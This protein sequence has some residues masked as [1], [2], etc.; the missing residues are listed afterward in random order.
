VDLQAGGVPVK[1]GAQAVVVVTTPVGLVVLVV[2]M[3]VAGSTVVVTAAPIC[4]WGAVPA[5]TQTMVVG[6]VL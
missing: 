5:A 3:P 6:E 1:P 4:G 2:W